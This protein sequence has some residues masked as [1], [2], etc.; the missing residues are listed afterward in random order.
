[1]SQSPIEET[2][3]R[4]I[5]H[6]QERY[7]VL[8][9]MLAGS[10]VA[11]TMQPHSD[12]DVFFIWRNEGKSMRG[13][14]FFEGQEFEYFLSPEWKYYDRLEKDLAAQQIYAAGRVVLDSDGR[15]EKI[16]QAAEQKVRDYAP[17]LT[18]ADRANLSFQVETV[19]K[20]GMDLLALGQLDNFRYLSGRH[21]PRFCDMA[22]KARGKYPVYQKYA[23]ERLRLVD[24]D[25][26]ALIQALYQ[27]PGAEEALGAWEAL[28]R[29]MLKVLGDVD[30]S[31]YQAVTAIRKKESAR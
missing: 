11:G 24:P 14:M 9:V 29:H 16:K 12:I 27:A 17:T 1:M 13:R 6:M 22:A 23:V 3:S 31:S 10:Y 19:M 15:F 5:A 20:D 21:I 28:C 25:L 7:G 18:G 26:T 30:I 4:F 2:I 8:S